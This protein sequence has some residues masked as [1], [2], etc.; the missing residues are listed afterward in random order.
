[1]PHAPLLD[2]DLMPPCL[3]VNPRSHRA[4][5]M[6][7]ARRATR[8]ARAAGVEVQEVVD[9]ASLRARLEDLRGRNVEQVW[10]LSGDGTIAALA[11][12]FAEGTGDWNPALLLLAGG[13]ANV[14]P[15][16]HGGYPAMPALRRALAALRDGPPMREER[17]ITLQVSQPGAPARNGFLCAGALVCEAV[18]LTAAHR[19]AGSGWWHK[20]WFADPF[21]LL[22]WAVRTLVFG[23][24]LPPDPQGVA[25]LAGAGELV[26][27]I[28]LLIVSTLEMRKA[29]YN[30]FAPRGKGPVRF[31]AIASSAPPTRRMLPALLGGR[32]RK[33]MD[34]A[35]GVLS[36]RGERAQVQGLSSYAL[37]GE[38]FAADPSVPVVFT[39]GR[40][41]RVLRP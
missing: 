4:S 36:G 11:D 16:E 37:D 25:R 6:G 35:H 17:L 9:P 38:V 21:I 41:L 39:A 19:A 29:L 24:P 15:R 32:F 7:Y 5:W 1:V 10:V 26:G 14:V 20:S 3:L 33:D 8:L 22:R 13:R 18:R 34:L 31:T 12:Y 30:P 40:A 2:N 27:G 28:R 23:K